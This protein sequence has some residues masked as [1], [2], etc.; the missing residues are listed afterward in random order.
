MNG[1]VQRPL[2]ELALAASAASD[3][4]LLR[5]VAALD[6]LPARGPADAVLDPVRPRLKA[7]RPERPMTPLRL[8]FLPL[9]GVIVAP[10]D[11]R[12][13]GRS[14][15]R[16]ALA[17]LGA[18]VFAAAGG[19]GE[20]LGAPAPHGSPPPPEA[21]AG[22]PAEAALARMLAGVNL[23]NHALAAKLGARLWPAAAAALPEAPPAGWVEAGLPLAA[24]GSL[25]PLVSLLWRH[26]PGIH[27]LRVAAADGP[28]EEMARPFFR[29]L[30]A[31][32]GE[33]V[34][35]ALA[36][37]LPFAAR[38]ASLIALVAGMDGA[39]AAPAERALDHF[40]TALTPPE[41]LADLGLA[42]AG[43]RRFAALVEDLEQTATRGKPHRGRI[44]QSLRSAAAGNCIAR[45]EV[46]TRVSLL[47]PVA[48]LLASPAHRAAVS[49]AEVERLE[50]A[51]RALRALADTGRRLDGQA[52]VPG[53][54]L[55]EA[56][57]R[58]IAALPGLPRAGPG[59]GRADALRLVEILSGSDAAA[60]LGR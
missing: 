31:E 39:L 23:S 10:R 38:P 7:L 28:P 20:G 16:N 54:G 32:G 5:L 42:A 48:E 43:A 49:D 56:G 45:L 30:A 52:R 36:A 47:E 13:E 58:L 26:G 8:L 53:D 2:R 44:L 57:A 55:R 35:V 60:A 59:F 14:L 1:P 4:Q 12:G 41:P 37:L 25:R 9:D 17:P 50:G 33:A 3:S 21:A 46:E 27:T 51:V 11:W 29:T 15:P 40:L 34:E 24:Y 19:L 6:R 18:A 22:E